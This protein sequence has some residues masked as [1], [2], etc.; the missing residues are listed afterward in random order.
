LGGSTN[1]ENCDQIALKWLDVD[2]VSGCRNLVG[3]LAEQYRREL[4][5]ALAREVSLL[6]ELYEIRKQLAQLTGVKV[7]PLRVKTEV[8]KHG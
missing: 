6:K 5:A 1:T 3:R 2:C 7:L 8:Q 4:E